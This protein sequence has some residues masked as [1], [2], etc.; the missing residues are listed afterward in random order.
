MQEKE[1]ECVVVGDGWVGKTCMLI[2]CSTSE[3]PGGYDP[4]TIFNKFTIHVTVDE[5]RMITL[6]LYDMPGPEDY[7]RLRPFAYSS[8]TD[9]VLVCFSLSNEASYKNVRE[10]WIGEVAEHCPNAPII[11][12]GTKLDLRDENGS[13]KSDGEQEAANE[14]KQLALI[15]YQRGCKMARKIKAVRYLECSALTHNGLKQVIDETIRVVLSPPPTS[16]LNV[17]TNTTFN[18]EIL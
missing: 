9:V 16:H 8:H 13:K 4:T 17:A 5:S 18:C 2:A 15:S 7:D 6:Q 10:R 12:V 3:C 11:L 1:I 14:K